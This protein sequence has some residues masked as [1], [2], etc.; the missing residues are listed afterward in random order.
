MRSVCGFSRSSLGVVRAKLQVYPAVDP[1]TFI[2]LIDQPDLNGTLELLFSIRPKHYPI[3]LFWPSRFGRGGRRGT[4]SVSLRSLEKL[5]PIS[6][7][8]KSTVVCAG[9]RGICELVPGIHRARIQLRTGPA[10]GLNEF[11]EEYAELGCHL[12]RTHSNVLV[13]YCTPTS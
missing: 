7:L 12:C 3:R 4:V 8:P 9:T 10:H 2:K 13:L 11:L 6:S 1:R 5:K